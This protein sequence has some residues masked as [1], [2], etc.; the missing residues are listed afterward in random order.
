MIS[1]ILPKINLDD[2]DLLIIENVGNLVC[3][4]SYDLG[5]DMKVALVS[6]TEGHD[7]PL[8]YPGMFRRSSIMVINKIDLLGTSDFDLAEVKNN[9]RQINANLIFFETSCRTGEGL[10]SWFQWLLE[11]IKTKKERC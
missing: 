9:A 2:L 3:P 6:T 4:A 5:E 8:K 11:E 7:K 1:N 10:E